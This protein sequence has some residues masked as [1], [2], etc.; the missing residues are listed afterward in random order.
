MPSHFA[1]NRFHARR[2][3]DSA[4]VFVSH[5]LESRVSYQKESVLHITCSVSWVS[6]WEGVYSVRSDASVV[7]WLFG[8]KRNAEA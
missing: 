5:S 6:T 2:L 4:C 3:D 1:L 8:T 7:C